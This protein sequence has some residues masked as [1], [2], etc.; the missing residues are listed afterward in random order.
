MKKNK[1]K[2]NMVYISILIMIFIIV[3]FIT[4]S[5]ISGLLSMIGFFVGSLFG[6]LDRDK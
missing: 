5:T 3:S 4:E 6:N 1:M 2:S